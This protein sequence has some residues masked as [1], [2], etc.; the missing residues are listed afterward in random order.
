MIKSQF[1]NP[2]VLLGVG[3]ALV[4]SHGFVA[5]HAYQWGSDRQKVA[6]QLRV[7]KINKQIDEQNDAIQKLNDTWEKAIAT[8]QENYNTDRAKDEQEIADLEKKV[9]D[10]ESVIAN[11][12]SCPASILNQRDIDSLN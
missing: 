3:V 7:D 2:W 9:S 10:Y 11:D 6:C 12:E 5:Y 1:L 8:V 4:A